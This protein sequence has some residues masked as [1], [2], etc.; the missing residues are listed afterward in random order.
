MEMK[1]PRQ[2]CEPR[3]LTLCNKGDLYGVLRSCRPKRLQLNLAQLDESE[4]RLW[5][6]SLNASLSA[7]G[8]QEGTIA[9]L[10]GTVLMG[11]GLALRLLAWPGTVVKDIS[12]AFLAL[13]FCAG[14]GKAF[15]KWRAKRRFR[16]FVRTLIDLVEERQ[17]R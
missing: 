8:C 5:N 1:S 15:G 17:R 9:L 6:R 7:C 12:A 10:V 11:V 14:L 13:A 16:H 3:V 2:R 4:Q